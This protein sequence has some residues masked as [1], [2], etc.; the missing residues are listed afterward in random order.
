MPE[1]IIKFNLPD[2]QDEY[3]TVFHASKL[4]CALHD[5]T[6][7]LRT[8]YKYGHEFRDA[9]DAVEKIRDRIIDIIYEDNGIN[10][11]EM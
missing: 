8:W 9:D 1:V 2:E 4:F 3:N 6:Q 7:Q 10:L 11:D 5:I